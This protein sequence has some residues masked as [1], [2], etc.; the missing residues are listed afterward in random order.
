MSGTHDSLFKRVFSDP[1]IALVE[2]RAL[3]PPA[4]FAEMLTETVELVPGSFVDEE[5]RQTH[6]DL[7]FQ[8]SL[9]GGGEALIY[10][11][12]EHQTTL[13]RRMPLRMLGYMLRIWKKWE[14]ERSAAEI[15]HY[16]MIVPL[17]LYQGEGEWT[18]RRSFHEMLSP[19]LLALSGVK[20]L[21]PDFR[22]IVDELSQLSDEVILGRAGEAVQ[23]AAGL[24]LLAMREAKDARAFLQ[25]LARHYLVF[26]EF[27]ES[28]DGPSAFQ[29]ILKYIEELKGQLS[30]IDVQAVIETLEGPEEARKTL[31]SFA[32]QL[33]QLGEK[34][35]I[36]KGRAAGEQTLL[37]RLLKLKFQLAEL[38]EWALQ[39]MS[40]ASE[41]ELLAFGDK[42]ISVSS[43]EEVFGRKP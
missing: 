2:F 38:P 22:I 28:P 25:T 30:I 1:K 33:T 17:V 27:L 3:V 11:L 13:D 15:E 31:M 42:V 19:E 4:L 35:G 16:P 39:A 5:L 6:S 14:S 37:G 8:S 43:L 21:V 23:M 36:Q 9:R 41:E 10:L 18:V 7:L 32:E 24:Y 29:L 40:Q 26:R 20:E 34:A 12:F